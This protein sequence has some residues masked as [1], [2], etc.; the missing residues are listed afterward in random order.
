MDKHWNPLFEWDAL[1]P[2]LNDGLGKP[3]L[4]LG[5]NYE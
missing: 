4:K 3:S 2:N 5:H 1:T